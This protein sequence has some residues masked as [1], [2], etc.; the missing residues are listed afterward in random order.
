MQEFS[1]KITSEYMQYKASDLQL[2]IVLTSQRCYSLAAG[3]DKDY[4]YIPEAI[5][6]TGGFYY[7]L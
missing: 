4:L 5:V 3:R 2:V 6:K 1:V 7:E